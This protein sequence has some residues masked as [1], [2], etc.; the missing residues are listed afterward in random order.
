M[1]ENAQDISAEEIEASTLGATVV[2]LQELSSPAATP[3]AA[4]Q[5]IK[6]P[7]GLTVRSDFGMPAPSVGELPRP[8]LSQ[9]TAAPPQVTET[10]TYHITVNAS[11]DYRIDEI[12]RDIK[13]LQRDKMTD[14]D[15]VLKGIRTDHLIRPLG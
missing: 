6:D 1:R 7:Y 2:A 13:E 8:F 4:V 10:N 15:L 5:G 14:S 3:A 12:M 11:K 9:A